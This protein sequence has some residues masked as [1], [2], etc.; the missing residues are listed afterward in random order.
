MDVEVGQLVAIDMAL[1]DFYLACAR[2]QHLCS[3]P[4][5]VVTWTEE[6]LLE[7]AASL[8]AMR[9]IRHQPRGLRQKTCAILRKLLQNR[10]H[11]H[12]Q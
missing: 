8:P 6:Q 5:S 1:R 9:T 2:V 3:E 12:N 7:M 4:E 10:T 11:C